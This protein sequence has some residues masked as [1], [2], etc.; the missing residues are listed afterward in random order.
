M[1][2]TVQLEAKGWEEKCYFPGA[3]F[4]VSV[5]VCKERWRKFLLKIICDIQTDGIN[6]KCGSLKVFLLCVC[7][8]FVIT[9]LPQFPVQRC[10]FNFHWIVVYRAERK[11]AK[12][13][14]SYIHL[15][16]SQQTNCN[17]INE[18]RPKGC[19]S[20]IQPNVRRQAPTHQT[21]WQVFH[22]DSWFH[23][24]NKFSRLV[25]TTRQKTFRVRLKQNYFCHIF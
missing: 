4:R 24:I 19:S 8:Y 20:H 17:H 10:C 6:R 25:Y 15:L 7:L 5:W 9:L 23:R 1:P 18:V 22:S 21:V 16:T 11:R 12:F 13:H 3:I 2:V 14:K